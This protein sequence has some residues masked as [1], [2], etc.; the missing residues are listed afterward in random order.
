MLISQILVVKMTSNYVKA[1]SERGQTN[2][3]QSINFAVQ[4]SSDQVRTSN[5]Y[6][7]LWRFD[8][9]EGTVEI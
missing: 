3:L 6:C 7:R 9:P 2:V 5:N 4:I 8:K 1:M